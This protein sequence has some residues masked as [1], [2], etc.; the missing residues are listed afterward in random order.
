[1]K[2]AT[3]SKARLRILFLAFCVV[4]LLYPLATRAQPV[5]TVV[6]LAFDTDRVYL[7]A[8]LWFEEYGTPI[9]VQFENWSALPTGPQRVIARYYLL[10]KQN[11][12]Q[13]IIDLY[14]ETDG[15]RER[16][17]AFLGDNAVFYEAFSTL[18]TLTLL[19][20]FQ[21]G[22]YDSFRLRLEGGGNRVDG[23]VDLF[24]DVFGCLLSDWI[25]TDRIGSDVVIPLQFG[26]VIAGSLSL[27]GAMVQE[28]ITR[29]RQA[30]NEQALLPPLFDTQG[31]TRPII[32]LADL[33]QVREPVIDIEEPLADDLPGALRLLM[34]TLKAVRATDSDG[35]ESIVTE[36]W[37]AGIEDNLVAMANRVQTT[38]DNDVV[39]DEK[40]ELRS[41]TWEAFKARTDTWASVRVLGYAPLDDQVFLYILPVLA[42]GKTDTVQLF[43]TQYDSDESRFRLVSDSDQSFAWTIVKEPA[44]RDFIAARYGADAP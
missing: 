44:F 43:T 4:V 8:E 7:A 41:Y 11:A 40:T 3:E 38:D 36:N 34:E 10:A 20:R 5:R 39:I 33:L 30:G 28:S 9:L 25:E 16:R 42:N 35:L 15:S 23:G 1:M 14:F 37:T 32:L 29:M 2:Y 12:P 26:A 24:C 31:M 22:N 19:D 13:D 18:G 6:P 21:W 27:D 17:R